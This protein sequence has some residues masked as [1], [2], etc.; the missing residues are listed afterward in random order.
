MK[1]LF[2]VFLSVLMFVSCSSDDS[3]II[4][5][6]YKKES[7]IKSEKLESLDYND[8]NL[9]TNEVNSL[10]KNIQ[11]EVES[12]DDKGYY[13]Y[14]ED[15]GIDYKVLELLDNENIDRNSLEVSL[16]NFNEKSKDYA[17]FV[18]DI[19]HE[20]I[21]KKNEFYLSDEFNNNVNFLYSSDR[22]GWRCA[23]AIAMG[24]AVTLSAIGLTVSSGG[25]LAIAGFLLFKAYSVQD[26]VENC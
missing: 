14:L 15:N 13:K 3:E 20:I 1:K 23:Q 24:T 26:I 12:I 21:D 16:I 17:L 22:G 5:E 6:N 8:F 9:T 19:K 11:E 25:G 18:F 4:D 10:V 2:V 7:N